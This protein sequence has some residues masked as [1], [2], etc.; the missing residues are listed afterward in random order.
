MR[1]LFWISKYGFFIKKCRRRLIKTNVKQ[2]RTFEYAIVLLF[3]RITLTML[4][5]YTLLKNGFAEGAL[6]LSR[7]VIEGAILIEYICKNKDDSELIER[8]FDDEEISCLKIQES[9]RKYVYEK[10]GEIINDFSYEKQIEPLSNRYVSFCNTNKKFSDYW[11]VEKGCSFSNLASKTELDK[12][13]P[14][15]LASKALHMSSFNCQNYCAKSGT[16]ILIG[17]TYD[18]VEEPAWISMLYYG[19]G[20][21]Y[22]NDHVDSRFEDLSNTFQSIVIKFSDFSKQIKK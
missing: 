3:S 17:K 6:G 2:E 5:I 16:G 7:S 22:L 10:H 1:K 11:W 15:V 9:I 8:F 14:Y 12:T 21:S 4:E 20:M 19:M 18:G 13:Y